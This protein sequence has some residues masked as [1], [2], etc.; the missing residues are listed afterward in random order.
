MIHLGFV[1]VLK[2]RECCPL[3][4]VAIPGLQIVCCLARERVIC[5]CLL[6]CDLHGFS[7]GEALY[8][9]P[10]VEWHAGRSEYKGHLSKSLRDIA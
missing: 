2:R 8:P 3:T 1:T 7:V 4:V 5:P 10:H 9:H 6:P